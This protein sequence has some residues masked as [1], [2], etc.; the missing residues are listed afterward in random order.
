MSGWW[1]ELFASDAWQSVQLAWDD[2][3]DGDDQA[4]RVV[5][6]LRLVPGE[7]VLDVPCGTGRI[8]SRLAARGL[9]VTG[10]DVTERFIEHARSRDEGVTYVVGDMREPFGVGGFDAAVCMW[11]SFGYFDDAG[12]LAQARAA[13]R[14]LRSGGRYLIDTPSTETLASHF[15]ERNWFEA[16]G[17]TVLVHNTFVAAEGR[18][19]TEWTF[20]RD[21]RRTTRLASIRVYPLREL[22]DLLREA[23][24]T[25]FEARDDELQPFVLGAARLW[26]VAVKD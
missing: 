5:E 17:T 8:A 11:G 10:V 4:E 9:A 6:A 18:V 2:V 12:N 25:T 23:G 19:D 14:S 24:F 22:T 15:R 1:H 20:L 26:L 16:G 21:G 13:A 7:R 3:E